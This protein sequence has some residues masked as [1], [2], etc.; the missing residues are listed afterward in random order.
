MVDRGLLCVLLWWW[1]WWWWWWFVEHAHEYVHAATAYSSRFKRERER[2][3]ERERK[4]YV[5]HHTRPA[6]GGDGGGGEWR[7]KNSFSGNCSRLEHSTVDSQL[8]GKGKVFFTFF[9]VFLVCFFSISVDPQFSWIWIKV[10]EIMDQGHRDMPLLKKTVSTNSQLVSPFFDRPDTLGTLKLVG[11]QSSLRE[12]SDKSV[13]LS[14]NLSPFK[15]L[16]HLP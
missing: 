6:R 9:S 7:V 13:K 15:N 14:R 11:F 1:W 10:T 8:N 3:R 4:T 16:K 5:P 2:E 12:W